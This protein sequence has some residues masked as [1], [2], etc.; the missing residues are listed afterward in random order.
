MRNDEAR[1]AISRDNNAAPRSNCSVSWYVNRIPLILIFSCLASGNE[2]KQFLELVYSPNSLRAHNLTELNR[3]KF[4]NDWWLPNTSFCPFSDTHFLLH[5]FYK[6]DEN[7]NSQFM[8]INFMCVAWSQADDV[9]F[10]EL[11]Q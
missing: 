7:V 2:T 1:R 6:N 4:G 3:L 5:E 8:C 10:N 11:V 9:K